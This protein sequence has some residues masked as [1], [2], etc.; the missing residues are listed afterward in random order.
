MGDTHP[1]DNLG[2]PSFPRLSYLR[3][4]LVPKLG[5]DLAGVPGEESEETLRPTVDDNWV[6]ALHAELLRSFDGLPFNTRSGAVQVLA[7]V[8]PSS[9]QS[10]PPTIESYLHF[11]LQSINANQQEPTLSIVRATLMEPKTSLTGVMVGIP[12]RD[13]WLRWPRSTPRLHPPGPLVAGISYPWSKLDVDVRKWCGVKAM[14]RSRTLIEM[15]GHFDFDMRHPVQ[16][17]TAGSE[18]F[19]RWRNNDFMLKFESVLSR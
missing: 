15:S 18:V 4:D 12:L 2:L 8:S 7:Q 11:S 17:D 6:V 9:T 5:F 14:G 13:S 1:W 19:F 3:V 16:T 10:T